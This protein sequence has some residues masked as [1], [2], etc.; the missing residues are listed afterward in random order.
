ML[1]QCFL[2]IFLFGTSLFQVKINPSTGGMAFFSAFFESRTWTLWPENTQPAPMTANPDDQLYRRV[3]LFLFGFAAVTNM[4]FLNNPLW[5]DELYTLDHFV[6][7]PPFAT[8]TDYHTTNNHIVFNLISNLYL[9]LIGITELSELQAN[10]IIIRILPYFYTLI[11]I[12]AFYFGAKK[13]QGP[14]F[15]IIALAIYIST[16][17]VYSFGAQAR[18]YSLELLF[19]IILFNLIFSYRRSP[20]LKQLTGISVIGILAL[21][22]LPS[23]IYLFISLLLLAFTSAAYSFINKEGKA[24]LSDFKLFLSLFLAFV[25]FALFFYLKK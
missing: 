13:M 1:V 24:R 25:F 6:L 17:Q 21:L 2:F 7:V 18:G 8:L 15:A 3:F 19:I 10:P 14:L 12:P 16:L 9:K 11:S 22:N 20:S 23:T 4:L 5:Q